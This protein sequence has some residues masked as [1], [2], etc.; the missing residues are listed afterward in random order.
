M[1]RLCLLLNIDRN[2]AKKFQRCRFFPFQKSNMKINR[3]WKCLQHW[4]WPFYYLTANT[5]ASDNGPGDDLWILILQKVFPPCTSSDS[6]ILW[7]TACT[8]VFLVRSCSPSCPRMWKWYSC[9]LPPSFPPFLP[10]C[11]VCVPRTINLWPRLSINRT[12]CG[13]RGPGQ[14]VAECYSCQRSAPSLPLCPSH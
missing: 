8:F 9:I 10:R 6:S 3:G 12:E 1:R 5:I 2:W 7:H 14:L 11:F 13:C 4:S